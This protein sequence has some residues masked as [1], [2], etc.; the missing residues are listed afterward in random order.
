MSDIPV[1][2]PPGTIVQ[3][4]EIEVELRPIA[5]QVTN[6]IPHLK[7]DAFYLFDHVKKGPFVARF[8]GT[9][10]KDDPQ[11]PVWLEL[12]LI[13]GDGSGQA[14]LAFAKGRDENGNKVTAATRDYRCR[15]SLLRTISSPSTKA[16]AEMAEAWRVA[17]SAPADDPVLSYPTVEALSHIDATEETLAEIQPPK[18]GLFK[19][20][21]G[22]GS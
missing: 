9:L 15:P 16:Q 11:D 18:K 17:Q 5:T 7:R 13:T 21:F 2:G 3:L 12:E 8:M 14:R 6:M 20:L 22:G 19:R 1:V 4:V 10:A